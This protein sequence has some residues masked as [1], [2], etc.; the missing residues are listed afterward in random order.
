MQPGVLLR[1]SEHNRRGTLSNENT[2]PPQRTRR[3]SH[4]N[5]RDNSDNP[6]PVQRV[7]ETPASNL[8][9]DETDCFDQIRLTPP[10]THQRNTPLAGQQPPTRRLNRV[11][12]SET[13]THV[14]T[15]EPRLVLQTKFRICLNYPK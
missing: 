8:F 13:N 15:Y 6:R 3:R 12:A 7:R 1:V 11:K 10:T 5:N 2:P 14:E 9:G 4:S